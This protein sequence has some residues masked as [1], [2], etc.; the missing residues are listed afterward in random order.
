M[1]GSSIGAFL[2]EKF[3]SAMACRRGVCRVH[4]ALDV[5]RLH[6]I[7]LGHTRGTQRLKKRL[8]FTRVL[9]SG[10][11]HGHAPVEIRRP[12]DRPPGGE[13][14]GR[15]I[16]KQ[17][18]RVIGKHERAIFSEN[19]NRRF[20]GPTEAYTPRAIYPAMEP[21]LKGHH[22]M[23]NIFDFSRIHGLHVGID[24]G[25]RAKVPRQQVKHVRALA[26]KH[27]AARRLALVAPP[28]TAGEQL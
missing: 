12:P 7:G 27:A 26:E 28:T 8:I 22:E 9:R 20:Y 21:R 23:G 15:R 6:N 24:T 11:V 3:W 19:V 14:I 1:I 2:Y 16:Q 10:N 17:P 18:Y 4:N 5:E 25:D 13:L